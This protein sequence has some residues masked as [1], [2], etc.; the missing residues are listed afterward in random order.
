MD[1]RRFLQTLESLKKEVQTFDRRGR[2]FL[3]SLPAMS[4]EA[5]E[6]LTPQAELEGTLECLLGDD[7][8]PAL[9]KIRELES[10]LRQQPAATSPGESEP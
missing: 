2:K 9:R 7:L 1:R 3:R 8:E 5:Y 4:E 6:A 10:L